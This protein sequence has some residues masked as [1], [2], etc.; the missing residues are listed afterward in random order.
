[1]CVTLRR[2]AAPM[3]PRYRIRWILPSGA[4]VADDG[5]R[6]INLLAHAEYA[7]IDIPQACGG[8]AEC[9][10][11]RV[12]VLSGEVTAPTAEER[13]LAKQ[14]PGIFRDGERLACQCRPRSDL[15]VRTL[16]VRPPDLRDR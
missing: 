3:D 8:Q 5:Y 7:D 6:E 13:D 11:C 4:H 16:K 10:T 14:H 9:G 15:E 1:M 12:L 2:G